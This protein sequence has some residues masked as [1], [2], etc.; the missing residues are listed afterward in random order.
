MAMERSINE[1]EKSAGFHRQFHQVKCY[2]LQPPGFTESFGA[3]AIGL[4]IANELILNWIE[5]EFAFKEQGNICRVTGNVS[6]AGGIGIGSRSRPRIYS[7]QEIAGM[8]NH[9]VT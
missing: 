7:S 1:L 8:K 9:L 4:I 6:L 3:E 5:V 2:R